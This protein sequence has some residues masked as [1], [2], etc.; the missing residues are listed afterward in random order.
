MR[1]ELSMLLSGALALGGCAA[2]KASHCAPTSALVSGDPK[3]DLVGTWE[4]ADAQGSP[5][6]LDFYRNGE[7]D[8]FEPAAAGG[9]PSKHS[10]TFQLKDGQLTL[11]TADA[12]P[13]TVTLRVDGDRMELKGPL[14]RQAFVRVACADLGGP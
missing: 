1:V 14:E 3:R 4:Q 5:R 6:Y 8:R 11:R 7:F 13:E 9:R 12:P 10:G 2:T